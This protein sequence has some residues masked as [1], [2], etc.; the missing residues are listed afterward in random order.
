MDRY[1]NIY[2]SAYALIAPSIGGSPVSAGEGYINFDPANIY[3]SIAGR[4]DI[5]TESEV[6]AT[7]T[8]FCWQGNVNAL[9]NSFQLSLCSGGATA[10]MY[11]Y[12]VAIGAGLPRLSRT[13]WPMGQRLAKFLVACWL[14]DQ[15]VPLTNQQLDYRRGITGSGRIMMV[16]ETNERCLHEL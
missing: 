12:G 9:F 11:G 7:L 8:N 15:T 3:N 4:G 16:E 5:P 1:G 6:K 2:A 14:G 13:W 10:F